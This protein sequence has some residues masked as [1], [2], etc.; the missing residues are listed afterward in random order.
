MKKRKRQLQ[1]KKF[2]TMDN[3]SYAQLIDDF[4]K[5][6]L[7]LEGESL[8]D[9]ITRMGGV[10]YDAKANGGIMGRVKFAQG[11]DLARFQQGVYAANQFD[12][13]TGDR[14]GMGNN[15]QAQYNQYKADPGNFFYAG[16]NDTQ[17]MYD[18][19]N[20]VYNAP[21][22]PQYL[23]TTKQRQE[24]LL[25]L[26]GTG[27][28]NQAAKSLI[29]NSNSAKAAENMLNQ[30]TA[31]TQSVPTQSVP[32]TPGMVDISSAAATRPED[33]DTTTLEE[34][35]SEPS[36]SVPT[37]NPFE[38]SLGASP[39]GIQS[40]PTAQMRS[41]QPTRFSTQSV[42]RRQQVDQEAFQQQYNSLSQ[43]VP[44]RM[45][46]EVLR[47]PDASGMQSISELD[48]IRDRVLS[49]QAAAKPTYQERLMGESWEMLS[50]NDQYVIADQYPGETPPKR[51]PDFVP[52]NF[53][54]GG[55]VGYALGGM[56]TQDL[57]SVYDSSSVLQDKYATRQDYLDLF[58]QNTTTTTTPTTSTT[59]T[60]DLIEQAP[61]AMLPP[62]VNPLII[63]QG[64]DSSNG[65]GG[66]TNTNYGYTSPY[67]QS[68]T[69]QGP[70][71]KD[72]FESFL[73][74]IGEGTIE[75]ENQN[76]LGSVFDKVNQFRNSP[77]IKYNPLNP[78]FMF[79]VGK[80]GLTKARDFATKLAEER[81]AAK[82]LAQQLAAV[83]ETNRILGYQDYGSGG[84]QDGNYDTSNMDAQGNYDDK[85]DPGQT[86]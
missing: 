70:M 71:T 55:R 72:Q 35:M 80:T 75:K 81:Q 26:T 32:T 29:Q 77:Y 83:A 9:Y 85:G 18:R 74:D 24:K 4:E 50:D 47:L 41:I 66:I 48:A 22:T 17:G 2:I 59:T 19:F 6:L 40:V 14:L 65:G 57:S 13:A 79:N 43:G 25:N 31:P 45:L 11:G 36:P 12:K 60:T 78:M 20:A 82:E 28:L 10:D 67:A 53:A 51:N 42:P 62:R 56:R 69:V 16:P 39:T 76:G 46:N 73:T 68:N 44:T 34:I 61:A 8:T 27:L 33:V 52:G 64:G 1:Q 86:E 38:N 84:V 15:I 54:T 37:N 30:S 3:N 49:E 21:Q 7:V 63:P 58:D 5:G 23:P